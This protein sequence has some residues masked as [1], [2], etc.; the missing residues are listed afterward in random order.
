MEDG[1]QP[2]ELLVVLALV[3]PLT[4]DLGR[5]RGTH[6][7]LVPAEAADDAQVPPVGLQDVELAIERQ[8]V[9]VFLSEPVQRRWRRHMTFSAGFQ[10]MTRCVMPRIAAH[11]WQA[12]ALT[13]WWI[14][15]SL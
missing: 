14:E 10:H 9:A 4:A 3:A 13:C 8:L 2:A 5:D 1:E 6:R 12:G 15:T 11:I 7:G